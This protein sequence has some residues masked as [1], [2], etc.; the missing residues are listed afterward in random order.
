MIN[1][2]GLAA[3][4]AAA[5]S[6]VSTVAIEA[7]A[8]S[9]PGARAETAPADARP[10]TQ[11][12]QRPAATEAAMPADAAAI[13]A[14]GHAQG[15]K[16]ERARIKAIVSSDAAKNRQQLAHSLAFNSDLPA[17]AAI[18]I[19]GD[20]PEAARASRLDG[21]VPQPNVDASESSDA[22]APAAAL[23]AAT[24]KMLAQKGLKPLNS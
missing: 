22:A 9:A 14:E 6:G 23:A 4:H 12:E 18:A 11:P 3:V 10:A 24:Q 5:H 7:S 13:R 21:L 20:S 8:A 16:A 1:K 15:A 19:L 2:S 17:E